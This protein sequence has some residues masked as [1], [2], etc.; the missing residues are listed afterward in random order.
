[1]PLNYHHIIQAIIYK[2][3]EDNAGQNTFLHD[4]GYAYRVRTFKLFT[5]GLLQG[6]YEIANGKIMFRE[7][8]QFEL[9]SPNMHMLRTIAE[10]IRQN[11]I[12]YGEQHFDDVEVTLKDE[13]IE[14]EN[15]RL[16]SI[17][18]EVREYIEEAKTKGIVLWSKDLNKLLKILDKEDNDK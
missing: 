13:T 16:H 14:Q 8:V 7:S 9:R 15:E 10:N 4:R 17:I 5:F 3:L 18:K 12:D 6:K 11:G 1:M 2:K